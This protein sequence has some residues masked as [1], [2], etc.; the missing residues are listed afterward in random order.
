MVGQ[1]LVSGLTFITTPVFTR[2]M[3][4]T[5]FGMFSNFA[6]VEVLMF[7]IVTLGIATTITKSKFDFSEDNDSYLLSCLLAS[8]VSTII[9]YLFV[10]AHSFFWV[11]VLSLPMLYIRLLFLYMLFYPAFIYK[12][13]QL[14]IYQKYQQYVWI[15][16]ISAVAKTAFSILLVV[17]FSDKM[18]GRTVGYVV[19]SIAI[20]SCVYISILKKAKKPQMKHVRY[21]V[22]MGLSLL[23]TDLSSSVLLL[24]DRIMITA[25]RGNT[26][27]ALYSVIS[28]VAMI[29]RAVSQALN[30][31]W[32]PWCLEH[33]KKGKVSA[34][35]NNSKLYVAIYFLIC[36]GLMF[37]SPEIVL[38]MGGAQ[39]Y[40]ATYAL[41]PLVAGT[42][43]AFMFNLYYNV[44]YFYGSTVTASVMTMFSSILNVG[45]NWFFISKY[46]YVSAAYTTMISY[47][48]LWQLNYL[49]VKVKLKKPYFYDTKLFLLAGICM[50]LVC[51]FV[52]I[53]FPFRWMRFA[54]CGLIGYVGLRLIADLTQKLNAE[55]EEIAE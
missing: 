38:L 14:S 34:I 6:S 7:S 42:F 32:N 4:K 25:M 46:G 36:V 54:L 28:S 30:Q 2:L 8:N 48:A 51:E 12:Q 26:E 21:G 11:S 9:F 22:K 18:L 23:P 13:L 47:F 20:Y 43:Y 29:G 53:T 24:S 10:E 55:G 27:N 39:Y 19:S 49:N 16:V 52:E 40:E 41:P 35:R 1:L 17:I 45:L 33:M 15:S 3:G 31:A 37:L 5:E 50:L 44:E